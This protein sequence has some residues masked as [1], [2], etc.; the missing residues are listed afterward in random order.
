MASKPK[1]KN[2]QEGRISCPGCSTDIHIHDYEGLEVTNCPSCNAP[3]FIPMLVKDYWLYKPLGGGGMGSVY[4]AISAADGKEYAIKILP[5]EQNTNPELISAIT[6]EGEI[7]KILGKAP[8]IAEVVD[9]GCADGEYFLASRFV[10]GTRLDVFISTASHLSERQA[11]DILLQVIDAEI[12]II[13]CGFLFRDIKPENIIVVEETAKV[14]LFDFGLCLSLEQAANPDETDALE[15]SPYYLP[16]ERIVAA[17]EGEHSEIYSLGML[18][19][20]MLAGQTYYSQSDIKDL[21]TKHVR[22]LRVASVTNRLKHCSPEIS[23]ILDK[24]IKRDPNQRYHHLLPLKEE[25]EALRKEA[26]GYSLADAGKPDP[27]QSGGVQIAASGGKKKNKNL[28]ILL[29]LLVIVGGGVGSWHFLNYQAEQTRKKEIRLA[30]ARR[31]GVPVDVA[32]PSIS[33]LDIGK[34]ISKEYQKLYDERKVKFPPFDEKAE[35]AEIC[36]NFSIST[37][38]L[39]KPKYTIAQL[40]SLAKKQIQKDI[41]TAVEKK[42]GVFSEAKM[43]TR[44]ADQMGIKMPVTAPSK[45]LKEVKVLFAKEADKKAREK[46]S[47]KEL[48]AKTMGIL[49]KYRSH[50]EG[51]RITVEDQAGLKTSGLYKGREGNKVVIGNRKVMLSDL[52]QVERIRFNPALCSSKAADMVKKVKDDFKKNRNK[53]KEEYEKTK[54]AAIFRKYGYRR[55]D[56]KWYS[57]SDFIDEKLEETRG[58][59]IEYQNLIWKKY[60]KTIK[61]KFNKDKFIKQHGYLKI[62]NKWYPEKSAVEKILKKKRDAY[63]KTRNKN[64]EKLKKDTRSE[65]EKKIYKE[66]NYIYFGNRWQPAV[67]ALKQ[68]TIRNMYQSE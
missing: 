28:L 25:L 32:A 16:P 4:Q 9:Y 5:R 2:L 49:K 52:T 1:V 67:D 42:T 24:M 18:L 40:N 54:G 26:E 60:E 44:I 19:F 39:K 66:N 14:K 56:G 13:N 58:K 17:S 27:Q 30:A 6:R 38:M 65:V 62:K 29:I 55:H 22:S 31:L 37:S 8:N 51:D 47:S 46:F 35:K 21:L 59:F 23:T 48:A 11:L 10:E 41:K 43:K 57:N 50:R 12:H 61:K 64:L 33:P 7:G 34:L 63:N 3:V 20:H 36:K 68:E 53:F 15:G 45:D